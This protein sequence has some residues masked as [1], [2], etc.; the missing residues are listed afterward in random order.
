MQ[1]NI[2]SFPPDQTFNCYGVRFAIDE[3]EVRRHLAAGTA[4]VI[5]E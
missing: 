4:R 3:A 2:D 5:S 1:A